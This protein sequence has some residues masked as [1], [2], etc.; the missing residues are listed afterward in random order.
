MASTRAAIKE[1]RK[2][3]VLCGVATGRGPV[4][5]EKVIDYLDLDMFITYN[6]QFVY[7]KQNLIYAKPF[8]KNI[9]EEIVAYADENYRQVM[10]GGETKVAGSLT[11]RL[12]QSPV[13]QRYLRFVPKKFPVGVLKI[14]AAIQSKSKCQTVSVS[15]YFAGTNLSVH[16]AES[17]IRERK[18]KAKTAFL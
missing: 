7:T 9:L 17:R 16:Y 13:M 15:G 14:A 5:L 11:I 6:G 18:A 4:E 3:G 12:S 1:A 2:Q 10:F 8:S